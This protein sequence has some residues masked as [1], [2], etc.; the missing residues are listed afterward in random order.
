MLHNVDVGW[1]RSEPIEQWKY[2]FPNLGCDE[3]TWSVKIR[4]NH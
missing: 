3:L 2:L 1:E 4:W